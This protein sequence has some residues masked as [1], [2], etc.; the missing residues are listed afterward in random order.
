MGASLE[1]RVR[2]V[3]N[4]TQV[5]QRWTITLN[6]GYVRRHVRPNSLLA[7]KGVAMIESSCTPAA[8]PA[9]RRYRLTRHLAAVILIKVILLTLLW[10]AFIKPNKVSIDMASMGE[11]IAGTENK[12]PQPIIQTSPGD[13]K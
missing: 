1:T 4:P 7:I 6:Y 11:R 3:K 5:I 9:G 12:N 2:W 13:K 8:A 10:Y